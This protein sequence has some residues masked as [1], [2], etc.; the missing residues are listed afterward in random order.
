MGW[1]M[2]IFV[3]INLSRH[4]YESFITVNCC[5]FLQF[6]TCTHLYCCKITNNNWSRRV[7]LFYFWLI[8]FL[9]QWSLWKLKVRYFEKEE[10]LFL[11][12]FIIFRKKKGFKNIPTTKINNYT[13]CRKNGYEQCLKYIWL[14][15]KQYCSI[16]I[17]PYTSTQI[18]QLFIP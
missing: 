8:L 5:L 14:T 4:F 16:N 2:W 9:L 6:I 17:A 7:L 12:G 11:P 13:R 15:Y 1:R 3:S 10:K 18:M